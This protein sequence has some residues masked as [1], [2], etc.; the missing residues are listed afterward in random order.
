MNIWYLAAGIGLLV[1]GAIHLFLG[2]REIAM[3]LRRCFALEPVQRWVLWYCWHGVTLLFAVLGGAL[4]WAAVTPGSAD[5]AVAV[6]LLVVGFGALGLA[7]PGR[8]GL[9]LREMPQGLLVTPP[10]LLALIGAMA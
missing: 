1:D 3:P 6:G 2:G 7:L 5:L 9:S 4:V 8:V 10:G